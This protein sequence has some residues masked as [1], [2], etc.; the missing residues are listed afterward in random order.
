MRPSSMRTGTSTCTSRN[1]RM[2]ICRMYWSRLIRLAARSNWL[3]TIDFPVMM[4]VG[5]PGAVMGGSAARLRPRLGTAAQAPPCTPVCGQRPAASSLA[6]ET[7][8]RQP[9]GGVLGLGQCVGDVH[10]ARP[11]PA[12]IDEHPDNVCSR[13]GGGRL[14]PVLEHEDK[15]RR[16]FHDGARDRGPSDVRLL[17]GAG[18]GEGGEAEGEGGG[19]PGGGRWARRRGESGGRDRGG[20]EPVRQRPPHGQPREGSRGADLANPP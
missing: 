2:R 6:N 19:G 17:G 14:G 13:R 16:V 18:R 11:P 20:S 5:G 10:L 4:R 8:V 9:P 15:A 7:P 12:G 1:G 3:S